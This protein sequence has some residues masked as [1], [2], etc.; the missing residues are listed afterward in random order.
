MDPDDQKT[1]GSGSETLIRTSTVSNACLHFCLQ[2][3]QQNN[4]TSIQKVV[5]NQP[6]L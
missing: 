5:I 3:P 2:A 6:G 1:Y 4:T